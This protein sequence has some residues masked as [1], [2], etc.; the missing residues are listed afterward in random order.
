[1][2]MATKAARVLRCLPA[3]SAAL[4]AARPCVVGKASWLAPNTI[5]RFLTTN[6]VHG[7]F[8]NY[9]DHDR[10]HL[11]A[12]PSS[13]SMIDAMLDFL[14]DDNKEKR[15]WWWSVLDHSNGLL[16]CNMGTPELCVCNPA[17]RQCTFIPWAWRRVGGIYLAFDPA[18][19]PHYEV[20]VVPAVPE[21][22][23]PPKQAIGKGNEEKPLDR[24]FADED[25]DPRRLMES[26]WPPTPWRLNMFSSRSGQWEQRDFIRQGE[27]A[28]TVGDMLVDQAEPS[29][30]GPRQRYAVY[31]QG[32]LYVHC[33]G[34]F[35]L[36]LSLSDSTYQ[37]I[38]T[39]SY[40]ENDVFVKPYLGRSEK[41]VY[42]G[43]IEESQLRVSILSELSEQQM[44]WVL[45]YQH[46]LAHYAQHVGK[47]ARQMDAH[48]MVHDVLDT[49]HEDGDV[50]A[51]TL[52]KERFDWDSDN[53][54]FFTI[55]LDA[56][57]YPKHFDI[58]GLHPYKEVVYLTTVFEVVGYHLN[59]SK[60]QYLG[61]SRP[62][63]KSYYYGHSNG[64]FEA[65]VYTPC[66]V[67]ELIEGNIDQTSS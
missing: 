3:W 51:I 50:A 45:K 12:R 2:A 36:R 61:N 41:G 28:G 49:D 16:L 14:P 53:D 11:F 54:D 6:K 13:D 47:Y 38:K 29:G 60:V 4:S 26:E 5:R 56:D 19:S 40:G 18:V 7:L 42:F 31:H 23:K 33:R 37:V 9:I 21:P 44:E 63:P 52:P 35:V 1:M 15:R 25:N 34:F 58:L 27:P 46:D 20:L 22:G 67:G 43:V 64:I 30:M 48:W 39:P 59:T 57:E 32:A 8:I 10:P 24:L 17:T 55:K 65:F 62:S 66:T